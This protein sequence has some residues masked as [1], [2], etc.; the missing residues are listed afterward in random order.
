MAACYRRRHLA[1]ALAA[2]PACGQT[3][4]PDPVPDPA[5]HRLHGFDPADRGHLRRQEQGP[6]LARVIALGHGRG[7]PVPQRLC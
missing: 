7:G 6:G 4:A 3:H 5:A 1:R 2:D